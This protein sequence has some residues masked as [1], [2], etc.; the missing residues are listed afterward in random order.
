MV[1]GFVSIVI[2]NIGE[3]PYRSP[4]SS[5]ESFATLV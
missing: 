5:L 2:V 1:F 3:N 4:T